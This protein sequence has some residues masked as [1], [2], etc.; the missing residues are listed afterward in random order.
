[1][2]DERFEPEIG[3]EVILTTEEI[4]HRQKFNKRVF[5][6]YTIKKFSDADEVETWKKYGT[7]YFLIFTYGGKNGT[8]KCNIICNLVDCEEHNSVKQKITCGSAKCNIG[9]AKCPVQYRLIHCQLNNVWWLQELESWWRGPDG[10]SEPPVHL[11]INPDA[12]DRAHSMHTK[13]K[14]LLNDL[15]EEDPRRPKLLVNLIATKPDFIM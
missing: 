9:T 10:T 13:C 4:Q 5:P 15:Y 8:S 7:G 14:N 3:L 12:V 6:W 1:M 11:N 2:N